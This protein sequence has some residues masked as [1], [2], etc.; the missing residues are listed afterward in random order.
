MEAK[1]LKNI[2]LLLLALVKMQTYSIK[3]QI[4]KNSDKKLVYELTG[5][6][7][8]SD[9]CKKGKMSATTLSEL[10]NNL[11]DVGLIIKKGTKYIKV[12]DIK[13]GETT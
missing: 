11:D 9:I 3:K 5:K 12:V 13:S 4:F 8:Q 1:I 2:E 6:E 10:R 7:T